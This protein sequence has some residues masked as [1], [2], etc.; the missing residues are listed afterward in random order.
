MKRKWIQDEEDELIEKIKNTS[1]FLKKKL[2]SKFTSRSN[3]KIKQEL[4]SNEIFILQTLIDSIEKNKMKIFQYIT[5]EHPTL[6]SKDILFNIKGLKNLEMLDFLFEK[7]FVSK[8]FL[9]YDKDILIYFV[10]ME[11]INV[12]EY[13]IKVQNFD[14]L[15]SSERTGRTGN[16]KISSQY[17]I[18]GSCET[19]KFGNGQNDF[20]L[21]S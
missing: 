6:I 13:L 2:I 15:Y 19:W 5:E 20:K 7:K 21:R 4:K 3:E 11:N 9:E 18:F 14:L 1:N 10:S 17:S 12:A 8:E 16:V